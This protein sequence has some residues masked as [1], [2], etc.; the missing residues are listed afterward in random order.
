MSNPTIPL[1]SGV[2]HSGPCLSS[3]SYDLLLSPVT[4]DD[5]R[6]I[7]FSIRD[8]KA[9]GPDGYSLFFFKRVWHIV[10][11][12]FYAAVQDFFLSGRLLGRLITPSLLWFLNQLMLHLHLI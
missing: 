2:I 7:V 12:D 11:E 6:K 9:P 8:D 3:S 4:H 5:I 10:G 1:D